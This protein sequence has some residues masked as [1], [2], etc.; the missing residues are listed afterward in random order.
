MKVIDTY[1]WVAEMFNMDS[2]IEK[3][4][5]NVSNLYE[6]NSSFLEAKTGRKLAD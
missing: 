4:F 1:Y 3:H 6:F 2:Q 5:I